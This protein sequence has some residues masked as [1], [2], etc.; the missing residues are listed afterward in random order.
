MMM[1]AEQDFYAAL[2]A[3]RKPKGSGQHP[4]SIM[5]AN[6]GLSRE[7]LG[8]WAIQHYSFTALP[9]QHFALLS[10]LPPAPPRHPLLVYLVGAAILDE[11]AATHHHP[12]RPVADH[13][14][15][16]AAAAG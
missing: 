2:E 4:F 16:E 9:P 5:W 7:Q 6:G 13:G 1:L 3:G 14:G 8:Q 15:V 10:P 12:L 11:P